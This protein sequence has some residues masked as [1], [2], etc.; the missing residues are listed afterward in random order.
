MLFTFVNLI[1]I[2]NYIPNVLSVGLIKMSTYSNKLPKM[3][4]GHPASMPLALL[5]C[6]ATGALFYWS[7]WEVVGRDIAK[8]AYHCVKNT[9]PADF[10]AVLRPCFN[11]AGCVAQRRPG[12]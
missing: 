10:K 7:A 1:Y 9:Q 4:E 12:L 2:T 11:P 3:C 5:A 8:A 6:A